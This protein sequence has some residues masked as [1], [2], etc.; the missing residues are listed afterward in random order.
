MI[1][2]QTTQ[3]T[4]STRP[5]P[6]F[7]QKRFD[8]WSR[9]RVFAWMAADER[10][11]SRKASPS[12]TTARARAKVPYS[13]G[14]SRRARTTTDTIWIAIRASWPS[15]TTFAPRAAWLPGP[16]VFSVGRCPPASWTVL[17]SDRALERVGRPI[18]ELLGSTSDLCDARR[19]VDPV[20]DRQHLVNG[21]CRGDLIDGVGPAHGV[22]Q[23]T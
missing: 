3:A 15:M 2:E 10:P 8:C 1:G 4:A 5:M 12:A 13:A 9:L 18:H 11:K 23:G 16:A 19:Q 6:E 14:V 21:G 17:N 22:E 7:T 20:D